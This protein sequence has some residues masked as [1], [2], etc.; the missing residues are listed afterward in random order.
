MPR[1]TYNAG[2]IV[3]GVNADNANASWGTFYEGAVVAGFP[4]DDTEHAVLQNVRA[5][6]YGR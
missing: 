5:V 6:G 1:R 3:L 4:A 2:G